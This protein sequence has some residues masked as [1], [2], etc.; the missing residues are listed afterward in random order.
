MKVKTAHFLNFSTILFEVVV[1]DS[2]IPLTATQLSLQYSMEELLVSSSLSAFH[3]VTLPWLPN[4]SPSEHHVE[5]VE[6]EE[7]RNRQR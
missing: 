6:M 1:L 4:H 3:N 7:G 5:K 2:A